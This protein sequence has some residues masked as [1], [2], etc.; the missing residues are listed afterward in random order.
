M[1]PVIEGAEE[2]RQ[3]S[4]SAIGHRLVTAIKNDDVSGLSAEIAYR[5]LF[6]IFPFGLFVAAL[7]A[8]VATSLHIAN[9]AEEI[10]GGLGDNLPPAIA[11]ALRPELERLLTTARA[12]LLA[13]GAIAALW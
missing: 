2:R 13:I 1:S 9:P 8:F 11:D 4:P 12:D 5:F 7:G 3:G 6:A 10:V